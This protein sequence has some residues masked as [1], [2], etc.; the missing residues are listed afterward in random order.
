MKKKKKNINGVVLLNKDKKFFLNKILNKIK[1]NKKIEK[2][3]Y[4]SNLDPLTTGILP[5]C[6]GKSL[7]FSKFIINSN[8]K[9]HIIIKLGEYSDDEDDYNNYIYCIDYYFLKN[10]NNNF[11]NYILHYIFKKM[12]DKCYNNNSNM[13]KKKDIIKIYSVELIKFK[14]NFI[15]LMIHCSK[16]TSIRSI[17]NKIQKK[18]R[19]NIY[20]K[21][22]KIIRLSYFLINNTIELKY[23]YEKIYK[24]NKIC[25]IKKTLLP[26]DTAV[27]NL[28][29][30][31]IDHDLSKFLIKGNKVLIKKNIRFLPNNMYR[32]TTDNQKKFIGVFELEYGYIIPNKFKKNKRY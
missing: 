17:I 20:I 28:P 23:F 15:E 24:K 13:I 14:D 12:M 30:L 2:Y 18:I 6:F 21:F 16:G 26:I 10:E 31:N 25:N 8:K 3:E 29:I 5:I 32:I 19:H 9:Y 27:S 1:N 11:R 4:V 7:N 22:I